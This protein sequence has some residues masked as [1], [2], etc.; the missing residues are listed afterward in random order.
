[1]PKDGRKLRSSVFVTNNKATPLS[2]IESTSKYFSSKTSDTET[3]VP[4]NSPNPVKRKIA[5]KHIKHI[6]IETEE[7]STDTTN[8]SNAL[9]SKK[10]IDKLEK[11][12]DKELPKPPVNWGVVYAAIKEFRQNIIAPVDTMGCERLADEPSDII[13][14]QT[15][16]FQS[17]V[18]LMLSSQ[19]K[20]QVTAAAIQNLRQKLL[21]GLNLD[22]ILQAEEKFLDECIS[23]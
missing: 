3:N 7:S 13:T 2:P 12:L 11:R 20:D 23:K 5:R 16:R 14:P 1:M 22:S 15:S 17:L 9:T 8:I 18:A 10:L 19:T 21:G 6:V 4:S